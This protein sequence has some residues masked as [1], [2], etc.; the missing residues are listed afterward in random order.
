MKKL[1]YILQKERIDDIARER[2]QEKA[3]SKR[4]ED[5]LREAKRKLQDLENR[6][7][8][9]SKDITNDSQPNKGKLPYGG[10][11][12]IPVMMPRKIVRQTLGISG[13]FA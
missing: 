7:A 11:T 13:A 9:T 6:N 5:E 10:N 12:K 8:K 1:L 4:L 3:A 2:D